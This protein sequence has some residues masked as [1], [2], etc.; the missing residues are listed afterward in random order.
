MNL[1]YPAEKKM[2]RESGKVICGI[3][4]AEVSPDEQKCSRC[5]G[6]LCFSPFFSKYTTEFRK[7]ATLRKDFNFESAAQIYRKLIT[8]NSELPEAY[9]G[10]FLCELKVCFTE[11]EDG[12]LSMFSVESDSVYSNRNCSLALKYATDRLYDSYVV[13]AGQ[14]EST[15]QRIIGKL[16]FGGKSDVFMFYD[17]DAKRFCSNLYGKIVSY[18][19]KAYTAELPASQKLCDDARIR[20]L[21]YSS[22]AVVF[23]LASRERTKVN[24]DKLLMNFC[25]DIRNSGSK[26][27]DF[28]IPVLLFDE[29]IPLAG[30][31]EEDCMY[32]QNAN[33]HADFRKR[34]FLMLP[35]PKNIE[36]AKAASEWKEIKT[37]LAKVDA[38][39]TPYEK[40]PRVATSVIDDR[41]NL[42]MTKE[43]ETSVSDD[44]ES[45]KQKLMSVIKDNHELGNFVSAINLADIVIEKYTDSYEAYWIKLL[46]KNKVKTAKELIEKKTDISSDSDYISAINCAPHDVKEKY[47]SVQKSITKE[48]DRAAKQTQD[49]IKNENPSLPV[50]VPNEIAVK[51][52]AEIS[53]REGEYI[54]SQATQCYAS[55]DFETAFKLFQKSAE[56]MNAQAQY[57]L[58]RCYENGIGVFQSYERAAFWYN[59]A[60]V[61][62]Q[63]QAQYRLGL[64]YFEG[65]GVAQSYENSIYWFTA[66]MSRGEV[67]SQYYLGLC[68]Y[69]GLGTQKDYQ[70]AVY[71]LSKASAN[72]DVRAIC[73]LAECY[74][75]GRGVERNLTKAAEWFIR[76][77][78]T[79]DP[80][81]QCK[82]GTC[83]LNGAGVPLNYQR[84]IDL[85]IKSAVQGCAEAEYCMGIC[86]SSGIGVGK[87][88][89]TA[90]EWYRKAAEK[91]YS[92]AL[93]NLGLMYEQGLGV[94]KDIKKAVEYYKR[95]ANSGLAEGQYNLGLCYMN[96]KGVSENYERGIYWFNRAARQ[97]DA[98]SLYN[99]GMF[100]ASVENY[101]KAVMCY[102]KAADKNLSEAEYSLAYCFESGQGT[103]KDMALAR[104][105]YRRAASHGSSEAK[106][107]CSRLKI[108]Y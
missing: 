8:K 93:C 107:E 24:A 76:A 4:G 45:E 66:A 75:K 92:E 64:C 105:Y 7:A 28:L 52:Q 12:T 94:S 100:Y 89:K 41:S 101:E 34:L 46:A 78:R 19:Y 102:Q 59:K 31:K 67:N 60:A 63:P 90:A 61:S 39:N 1:F 83:Y 29:S 10:L 42:A 74:Q 96:A 33:F 15:R 26:P 68:Y 98:M 77:A 17:T 79:G 20:D 36:A 27:D 55:G 82:L 104:E 69:K 65:Q 97:G 14:I 37:E 84:A 22:K 6:N 2:T 35:P 16:N 58:G 44:V 106:I 80:T 11:E 25:M 88:Y 30:M 99:I 48:I 85:Y 87:N 23:I 70:R 72:G 13:T 91:N 81:A 3:C 71:W 95:A 53:S 40:N 18:G 103:D 50:P 21:F 108:Q 86:Y 51:K 49:R 32:A 5:G 47:V 9:W 54:L 56:Y 38:A 62:G 57:N 73:S 43:I